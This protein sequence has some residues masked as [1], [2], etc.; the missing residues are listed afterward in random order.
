M[1]FVENLKPGTLERY[2][3]DYKTLSAI[4][5]KLVYASLTG[6]GQAGPYSK[7][8]AYDLTI[9]AEGGLM[10]ITGPEGG[11]PV[12]VGVPIT[13]LCAGLYLYSSITAALFQAQKYGIGQHI[14][15]PM[16]SV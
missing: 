6:Y 12:R 13:D 16:L 2:S 9:S 10:S 8:S 1:F 15:V 14:D 4:N 11:D 7:K 3:L 5:A